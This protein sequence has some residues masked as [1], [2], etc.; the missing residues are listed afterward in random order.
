MS[1][2][3]L[4]ILKLSIQLLKYILKFYLMQLRNSFW[5]NSIKK[6]SEQ[7]QENPSLFV[8]I[9]RLMWVQASPLKDSIKVTYPLEPQFYHQLKYLR[10]CHILHRALWSLTGTFQVDCFVILY[11]LSGLFCIHWESNVGKRE[12]IWL[13]PQC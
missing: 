3:Y 1:L 5:W 4:S 9:R 7:Q 10:N 12:G 6:P 8:S 2:D 13:C 11:S